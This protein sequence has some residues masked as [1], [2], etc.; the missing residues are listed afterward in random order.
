VSAPRRP[1]F[2]IVEL[3]V[4]IVVLSVLAGLGLLKYIDLRNTA[5]TASLVADVR[6]VTV[7]AFGYYADY[8]TWPPEAAAGQVPVG[9]QP[10][11]GGELSVSFDR[12]FYQLDFENIDLGG[13]PMVGVAVHSADPQLLAKF[14]ATYANRGP[15]FL[16]GGVLTYVIAAPGL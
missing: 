4:V 5:R 2:T 11:L 10:Y 13:T 12:V 1:G 14:I 9:L 8:A 7:G 16:N 15:F 3:L 6:A